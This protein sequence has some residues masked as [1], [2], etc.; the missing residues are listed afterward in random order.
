MVDWVSLLPN[1]LLITAHGASAGKHPIFKRI[2]ALQQ[3]HSER[4]GGSPQ[5]AYLL[6]CWRGE[7]GGGNT[8]RAA[9]ESA[10]L[11]HNNKLYVCVCAR[12]A[13]SV[14]YTVYVC[15]HVCVVC[16]RNV[17]VVHVMCG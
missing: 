8:N 13:R 6:H 12:I 2:T 17:C 11:W 16:M 4:D 3:F 9:A 10:M 5:A 14:V 15:T 1:C 7:A